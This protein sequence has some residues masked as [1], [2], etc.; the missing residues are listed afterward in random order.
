M[1]EAL[2]EGE[3]QMAFPQKKTTNFLIVIWHQDH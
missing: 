3:I 2:V 1:L